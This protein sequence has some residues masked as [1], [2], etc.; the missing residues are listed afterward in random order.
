MITYPEPSIGPVGEVGLKNLAL[1]G[2][3][4]I[5]IGRMTYSKPK[6]FKPIDGSGISDQKLSLIC[7]ILLLFFIIL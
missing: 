4:A 2:R 7:L 5:R 3:I 1:I 6:F